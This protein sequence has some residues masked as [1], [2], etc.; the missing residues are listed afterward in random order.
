MADKLYLYDPDLQQLTIESLAAAMAGTPALILTDNSDQIDA[1]FRV[2]ALSDPSG[3]SAA[4]GAVFSLYPKDASALF[5]EIRMRF[6]GQQRL[7]DLDIIDHLG[8]LTQV[9]FSNISYNAELAGN[10]F[11]FQVPPGTDVIGELP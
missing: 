5:A 8:Q 3:T 10:E 7:T 9:N 2:V 11:E 1:L 4:T 6:N